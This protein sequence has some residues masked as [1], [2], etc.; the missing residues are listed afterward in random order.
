MMG[1]ELPDE[2]PGTK[3]NFFMD[4]GKLRIGELGV[5]GIG[6]PRVAS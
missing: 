3:H 2:L 4:T 5:G 1:H 6:D